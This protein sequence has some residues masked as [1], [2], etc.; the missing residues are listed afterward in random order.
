M[1]TAP[2]SSYAEAASGGT[3]RIDP[4]SG[5]RYLTQNMDEIRGMLGDETMAKLENTIHLLQ[6]R[7]G[8][9]ITANLLNRLYLQLKDKLIAR[10]IKGYYGLHLGFLACVDDNLDQALDYTAPPIIS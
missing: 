2:S 9:T 3:V 1:S 7:Y 10:F 8:I 5:N 6:T 4:A